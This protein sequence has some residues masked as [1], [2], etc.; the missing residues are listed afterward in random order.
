MSVLQKELQDGVA[1]SPGWW[2][3]LRVGCVVGSSGGHVMLG[4]HKHRITVAAH[5]QQ[6]GR[7]RRVLRMRDRPVR[8]QKGAQFWP[9]P[10][11]PTP[12]VISA[13]A[14]LTRRSLQA[15]VCVTYPPMLEPVARTG[16]GLTVSTS[17]SSR[18]SPAR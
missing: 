14:R 6:R 4:E 7:G 13:A 15:S 11:P 10:V 2:S 3:G 1:A 18:A 5:E 12:E 17:A 16:S 9:P 8:L